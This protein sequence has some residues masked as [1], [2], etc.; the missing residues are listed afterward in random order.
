MAILDPYVVTQKKAVVKDV[1]KSFKEFLS[2]LCGAEFSLVEAKVEY[3]KN[4][5][6]FV[7]SH[8][9][10]CDQSLDKTSF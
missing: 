3:R 6:R 1:T 4:R 9:L 7:Y 8:F 10:S 5:Q 2:C